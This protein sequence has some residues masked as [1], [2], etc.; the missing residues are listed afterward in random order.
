MSPNNSCRLTRLL[1][2]L[3]I[4]TAPAWGAETG[5]LA[6]GRFG[7]GFNA[8]QTGQ[9]GVAGELRPVYGQLPLTVEAWV[10]LDGSGSYNMIASNGNKYSAGCWQLYTAPQTGFFCA[11]LPPFGR[12]EINSGVSITDNQWHYVAMVLEPGRVRLYV[13]GALRKDE[14]LTASGEQPRPAEALVVGAYPPDQLGC[15]GVIDELR[16]SKGARTITDIPRTPFEPDADTIGLWRFDNDIFADFSKVPGSSENPLQ[17]RQP[18]PPATPDLKA[19]FEE[20]QGRFG[21]AFH[22]RLRGKY[23]AQALPNPDYMSRAFTV[24]CWVKLRPGGGRSVIVGA[25][26][27]INSFTV[28]TDEWRLMADAGEG[29]LFA[30]LPGRKPDVIRT[31]AAV[32][33]GRWHY[34]AMT[35]EDGRVRLFVDGTEQANEATVYEIPR[36]GSHEIA[37]EGPLYIGGDHGRRTQLTPFSF[38]NLTSDGLIDELRISRGLRDIKAVPEAPFA[39]DDLTAGLWHFDGYDEKTGWQDEAPAGNHARVIPVGRTLNET[40]RLDF[41]VSTDPFD[42]PLEPAPWQAGATAGPLPEAE[43]SASAGAEEILLHGKWD[44]VGGVLTGAARGRSE[45]LMMREESWADSFPAPVPGTIQTALLEAGKIRNPYLG[46]NNLDIQWIAEREWWLRR[47]FV[48]PEGWGGPGQRLRLRFDGVDYRATFWLN[49]RLLG[50]H[51]GMFGGPEYEVGDFL[52]PAGKENVLIVCLDPAPPNYQ[53][54]FKNN[55]AYGWYYARIITLGI[56]RPVRLQRRGDAELRAPFLQTAALTEMGARVRLSADAWNGSAEARPLTLECV[57]TPKNFQGPVFTL[58]RPVTLQ[59]GR[60]ELGFEG[61][62]PGVRLWWPNG[63]GE[64]DLYRFTCKLLDGETVLDR[65]QSNW[66]A[67]TLEAR[68]VNGK[69]DPES[70][71]FQLVVNGRPVW[72]RGANWCYPDAL[73]RLDRRRQARFIT[74]ARHANVNLIRVWGGGPVENDHLYD[75]CDEAGIMAQQEF[76][77][78]GFSRLENIPSIQTAEMARDMAERL[79]NR[80][81]LVRWAGAN[82]TTGQGRV[83]EVLGRELLENDGTR[84]FHRANPYGGDVHM[85]L[86]WGVNIPMA[87]H[88]KW[89]KQMAIPDPVAFT[90]FGLSSPPNLE[91][92][93]RIFPESEWATWPPKADSV[94]VHHNP[95]YNMFHDGLLN[96]YL[97]DFTSARDLPSAIK[98]LQLAHSLAN[99]SLID[100]MRA[101]KPATTATFAYRL[102]ENYPGTSFALID[103]YGVPKGSLYGLRRA[104]APVHAMATFE[105]WKSRDGQLQVNLSAVNDSPAAVNA[106]LRLTLL[107]GSWEKLADETQEVTLPTERALDLGK[108]SWTLPEKCE[109][110]LFLK[111][112]LTA[113]GK[114]IDRNIYFFDFADRPGCLFD[115]PATRLEAELRRDGAGWAVRV[116]NAGERPAAGVELS[117]GEASNTWYPEDSGFWLEPNEE[118]LLQLHRTLAADGADRELTTLTVGAW[119]APALSLPPPPGGW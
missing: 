11:Y 94:A 86:T 117:T 60:N 76:S 6:E 50:R 80:P 33:D 2:L 40:D 24:E 66:G 67:R 90:E 116:R 83:Y 43:F 107:N 70:Y 31:R 113:G 32:R 49:G 23:G 59:P 38:E 18:A 114:L 47:K 5:F 78:L 96:F 63:M 85:H 65:Y 39:V 108:K 81:S 102:T 118:R 87:E 111:M 51:E 45:R 3:L 101:R 69:E 26:Y 34:L 28:K 35:V 91:T 14:P 71:N 27:P 21:G 13:D 106:T 99:S 119:N 37:T 36:Q 72:E 56:W 41:G 84:S 73:L 77:L 20:E 62:L 95:G 52:R 46:K 58:R 112:E 29:L 53:D 92:W 30:S 42:R 79:R 115:R 82:E 48:T 10:K 1:A 97:K 7:S 93:K 105:D 68:P 100:G 89:V 57:L 15:R 88:F 55:C 25:G 75:L 103:L 22:P 74:L 98:G 54:T 104:Y 109:R 17:Y 4:F 64:P 9:Q 16:I 8:A 44:C 12:K 19:T 110:P 61:E